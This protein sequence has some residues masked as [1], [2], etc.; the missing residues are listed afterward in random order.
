MRTI[1]I[2]RGC[3]AP[4]TCGSLAAHTCG[5]ADACPVVKGSGV[6]CTFG[7]YSGVPVFTQA[8]VDA[9]FAEIAA[10]HRAANGIA[11]NLPLDVVDGRM[12]RTQARREVIPAAG[13]EDTPANEA[14]HLAAANKLFT[15]NKTLHDTNPQVFHGATP[16][17]LNGFRAKKARN[18]SRTR[19]ASERKP[20]AN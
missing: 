1:G 7:T 4:E 9:R 14:A 15:D 11:A 20:R 3:L 6:V 16:L 2:R 12:L 8:D 5:G 13:N 17:A 10:A 18:V 19:G